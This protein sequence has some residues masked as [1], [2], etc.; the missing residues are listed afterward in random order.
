MSKKKKKEMVGKNYNEESIDVHL[1]DVDKI[2]IRPVMYLGNEPIIQCAFEGIDNA[3]DEFYETKQGSKKW[4]VFIRYEKE[5]KNH[6]FTIADRGRG[7]PVGIHKK[8]KISTLTAVL[9]MLQAGGK[10][11]NTNYKSSK[12]THGTGIAAANAVSSKFEV[13][14]YR[15]GWHYQ[16]FKQGKPTTEVISKKPFKEFASNK[17]GTVVKFTPDNSLELIASDIFDISTL[18][19]WIKIMVMVDSPIKVHLEYTNKK[20]SMKTIEYHQP[21]GISA[22]LNNKIAEHKV[23]VLSKKPFIYKS[24]MGTVVFQWSSTDEVLFEGYTNGVY[25]CDGGTHIDAF[26]RALVKA[27]NTLVKVKKKELSIID[28]R[29][30]LVGMI[31]V[32]IAGA[33]YDGQVKNKLKS[34]IDKEFED[35]LL[36]SILE[37][38]GKNKSLVR[39]IG[40]RALALKEA[41]EQTKK[42]IK[43]ATSIKSGR[44]RGAMLPGILVTANPATP[45]K[46]R[47]LFLVEGDS[48][49][50]PAKIARDKNF[51]EVMCLTGKP[52]NAL[53][54][55]LSKTLSSKPVQ[56]ILISLGVDPA[57]FKKGIPTNPEFRVGRIILLADGDQD[58]AH[59]AN[60]VLS[61]LY[62]LVPSVFTRNMVYSVDAPLY[63]ASS[64]KG[65]KVYAYDLKEIQSKAK[66]GW[67][68]TRL[69][70][71]GECPVNDLADIA[72][73]LSTRK[74]FLIK[75]L[76][77][78]DGAIF[79][80]IIGDDVTMRKEILGIVEPVNTTEA[81][82][83]K[84]VTRGRKK[85]ELAEEE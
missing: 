8:A 62:K 9:T 18:K 42:I 51:Q 71:W 34:K 84:S 79:D 54:N 26:Y 58:G 30:G 57:S 14:T 11:D 64:K 63:S 7:I 43:A 49:S 67:T 40:A 37:Y 46:D 52:L 2:R 5:G 48:A 17:C 19:E 1:L 15:D 81:K 25:N 60:L 28:L 22:Y 35:S 21:D 6:T 50:G 82:P 77:A 23:D 70:G 44:T 78:K 24:R 38:F 41:R 59:I 76:E 39:E 4:N 29:S 85:K 55:K 65:E 27:Y 33:H 45:A 83:K 75:P 3:T 61:V 10:F 74:L 72:F 13:W 69:K 20:G 16:A 36:G 80:R 12:G 53:R 31:N 66:P 68:I 47:E 56:N 32:K 73:D